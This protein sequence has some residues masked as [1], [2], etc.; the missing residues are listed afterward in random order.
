MIFLGDKYRCFYLT[1][2]L[3][4]YCYHLSWKF[5]SVAMFCRSDKAG[6]LL[7]EVLLKGLH[8][9]RYTDFK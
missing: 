2:L 1:N 3:G 9:Q 5:L 4:L 6:V 7:A 8:G